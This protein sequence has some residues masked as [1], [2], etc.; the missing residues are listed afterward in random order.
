[1]SALAERYINYKEK[2]INKVPIL[3]II[4]S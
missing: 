3:Y 4:I 1:M 2:V